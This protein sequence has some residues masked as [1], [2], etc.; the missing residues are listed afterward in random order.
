MSLD[1]APEDAGSDTDGDTDTDVDGDSDSDSGT[2]TDA[3]SDSDTDIDTDSDTDTVSDTTSDTCEDGF[4]NDPCIVYVDVDVGTS[5]DGMSWETAFATVQEG[6]WAAGACGIC[7]VWVAEG[8]YYV[9]QTA[10]TD[11]I[12]LEEDVSVYGGFDGTE[13]TFDQRDWVANVTNLDGHEYEDSPNQV[14]HVVTGASSSML[15]GF[16]ITGGKADSGWPEPATS[17]GGGI[18]A[19]E[20]TQTVKNCAFVE[21]TAVNG[22]GIAV[23]NGTLIVDGCRFA[24]NVITEHG[25]G[26]NLDYDSTATI[27]NS[28]F[29]G[30][31]ADGGGGIV[32]FQE[33]SAVVEN[34]VFISNSAYF[35]A[36]IELW[37]GGYADS[38]VEIANSTFFGNTA[39]S[40]AAVSCT[41][42][43]DATIV[44]S[45]VWGNDPVVDDECDGMM[46]VSYSDVEAAW[47]GVGNITADPLF[48]DTDAGDLRLQAGSPCIDASDGSAAPTLDIEGQGRFDDTETPNTGVGPPWADIGAYE[49]QP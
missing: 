10:D 22:G 27:L 37:S 49:Y 36:A 28:I 2:D 45:I 30:N 40:G 19:E 26:I 43:C 14:F 42:L 31:S 24:G 39:T 47:D 16:T 33:C 18:Y 46:E 15:D 34:C 3:D 38:I 13:T 4:C 32:V 29:E 44:G 48:V 41:N 35:G 23:N 11:T 9:W 12:Q 21:N 5:C 7:Q 6:I 17:S 25:A 20:C 8:T 1:Q